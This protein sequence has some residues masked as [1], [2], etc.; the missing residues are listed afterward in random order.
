MTSMNEMV[1]T[2]PCSTKKLYR[3]SRSAATSQP[4]VRAVSNPFTFGIPK[5]KTLP[6]STPSK[7]ELAVMVPPG[8]KAGCCSSFGTCFRSS[9]RGT[10]GTS[11]GVDRARGAD[12]RPV[13]YWMAKS[14]LVSAV[15]KEKEAQSQN[16]NDIPQRRIVL[17]WCTS[18]DILWHVIMALLCP[19]MSHRCPRQPGYPKAQI[20][21]ALK[22]ARAELR[23]IMTL[24]KGF[25]ISSPFWV[26]STNF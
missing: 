3:K 19:P 22:H 17:P 1:D 26:C 23:A 4:G 16:F 5:R 9:N 14:W 21:I 2:V 8:L 11:W 25:L 7:E 10:G 13:E 15:R 18:L 20:K 24:C 12:H 6:G